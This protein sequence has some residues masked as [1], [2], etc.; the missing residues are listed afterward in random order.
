[1]TTMTPDHAW[2]TD[3]TLL[4]ERLAE[5]LRDQGYAH[6][7][8]AAVALA[9]RANLACD[10][11]AFATRLGLDLGAVEAIDAGAVA[12]DDLPPAVLL[13]ARHELHL[14][15]DHLGSIERER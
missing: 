12:L 5:R 13:Q 6:P 9:V 4:C 15:L 3:Q 10:R 11:A 7:V 8:S 1:M 2:D 14:D